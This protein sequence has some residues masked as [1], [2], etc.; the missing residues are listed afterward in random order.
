MTSGNEV[1]EL[2]AFLPNHLAFKTLIIAWIP[3]NV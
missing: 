2:L 1:I 3:A